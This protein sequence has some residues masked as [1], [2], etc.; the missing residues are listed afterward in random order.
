[1]CY[2]FSFFL[3]LGWCGKKN[4]KESRFVFLFVFVSCL[5]ER[6]RGESGFCRGKNGGGFMLCL[7][8]NCF[9]I[10]SLCY[11]KSLVHVGIIIF[12]FYL[13]LFLISFC[14]P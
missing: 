5:K 9:I 13:F 1:M 8:M 11:A 7:S 14:S 2:V 12:F 4:V 3:L 6:K 10:V